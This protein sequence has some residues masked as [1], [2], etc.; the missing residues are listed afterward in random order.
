MAEADDDLLFGNALDDVGFSIIGRVVA[1]LNIEGD[2]VG[3]AMLRPTQCTNAAGNRRI[4][5]GAG[6]G[7]DAR[8]KC[9]RVEFVLGV[10]HQRGVHRPDRQVARFFAVQQM[11][12]V[13]TDGISIGFHVD[14]FAV[15]R[16]VIPVQQHRAE[17]GHHAVGDV[18]RT[19]RIVVIL[20]RQ[21]AAERRAGGA[22]YIH[23]VGRRRQRFEHVAYG[24]WNAAHG[25]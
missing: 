4:H 17:R 19:G 20:F 15:H 10:Q 9:G 12:E 6:A 3:A 13:A 16:E 21:H 25:F 24:V 5:V 18:A 7:D 22:Q 8:G 14:A 23:R 11:Q 2:F 1:A